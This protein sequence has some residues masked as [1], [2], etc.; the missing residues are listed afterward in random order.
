M[1]IP[2]SCLYG[3]YEA[4]A[5]SLLYRTDMRVVMI[6]SYNSTKCISQNVKLFL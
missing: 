4:R 3:K 2:P 5:S 1:S 6:F